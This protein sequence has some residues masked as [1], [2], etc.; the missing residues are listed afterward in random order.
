MLKSKL[1]NESGF[2]LIELIIV[3]VILSILIGLGIPAM[4]G[5]RKTAEI[6]TAEA[7][8][9]TIVSAMLA[10]EATYKDSAAIAG[11]TPTVAASDLNGSS[12]SAFEKKVYE[13]IGSGFPGALGWTVDGGTVDTITWTSKAGGAVT[14]A[15]APADGVVY[16][17]D[18]QSFIYGADLS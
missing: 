7:N 1:K 12:S 9:R 3:I 15:A 16:V 2:T 6:T 5:I 11:K 4:S 14:A 18:T 17:I 10:A 13:M 8:A